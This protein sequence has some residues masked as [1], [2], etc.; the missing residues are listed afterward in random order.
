MTS[1]GDGTASLFESC[2]FHLVLTTLGPL[3]FWLLLVV[4]LRCPM[5]LR[6]IV[7]LPVH[8]TR[9]DYWEIIC[10]NHLSY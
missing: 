5:L 2:G 10:G 6:M 7:S 4:L 3:L 1:D 9:F 8:G